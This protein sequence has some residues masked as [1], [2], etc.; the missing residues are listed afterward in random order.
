MIVDLHIHSTASDGQYA[1]AEVVRLAKA[2]G[3]EIVALTDHDTVA[4]VSE[5]LAQG[6]E[7]GMTVL[8]G[9]EFSAAEYHN[10]HILGYGMDL[11]NTALLD[12]CAAMKRSR[13]DHN[14]YIVDFLH[15]HGVPIDLEEVK[16]LAGNASIGRP[17]F[18]QIMLRHGWVKNS[19][20]AFDRY[21]DTPEY[22]QVDRKKFS[23]RE[24]VAAI[25]SAGG[26]PVLAHP[27]QLQLE[28]KALEGE[29]KR[30]LSYGLLGI[31]CY[32]PRHTPE[33]QAFYLRL[34][35]KYH[36]Y[37]T[38]GSDFHGEKVHPEDKFRPVE[39]DVEWL[40]PE[41]RDRV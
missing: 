12:L 24:C 38:A 10:L 39:L 7:L 35:E 41:K 9:V 14:T 1:P 19:R 27:Y 29:V 11:Q 40:L 15:R 37:V 5:A 20:E 36:L 8:I 22:H 33:K 25:L 17:H 32:Y 30:L 13:E 3:V 18:A 6:R 2:A 23:A 4:G 26:K 21:L 16:E 31:E 28:D 34:A